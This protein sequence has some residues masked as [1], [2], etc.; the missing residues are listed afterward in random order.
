TAPA[1]PGGATA[2]A[3]PGGP[4][5]SPRP[6]RLQVRSSDLAGLDRV[7]S[8]GELA[9][10]GIP[11]VETD[12]GPAVVGGV[13]ERLDS[14][15]LP[16]PLPLTLP[17]DVAER[18][19]FKGRTGETLVVVPAEGPAVVFLGTGRPDALAIDV[20][21][22]AAAS[23][24]RSAGRRGQA[25]FVLPAALV[26]RLPAATGNPTPLPPAPRRAAQAVTGGAVLAAYRFTSHKSGDEAHH[27]DG[28]VVAGVDIEPEVLAE[29]VRRGT[30][31][32]RAVCFARDLV[33]EPPSTMTP[34]R[35]A[36]AAEEYLG[37]LPALSLEVWDEGRIEA[38]RLGGLLAV[39]RGSAEPP[40]LI[41]AAFE[42]ADPVEVEGRVPHV[43]LVGKGITFD[44]GGLSLKTAEGMTTMKTDMSGAAAVL[45]VVGACAELA[46]RVRVTAIAPMTENMPGGRAQKP[47]D[48]LVARNGRTIEVLNTDAEGRL[49]LADG[50]S[51]ASELEPDVIIDL[52]T[53]TGAAVVALGRT[54]AGLFANDDVLLERLGD[55]AVGAGERTWPL[56]LAD[57][58]R[59]DIDSEVADMKNIGKGGQ[60][61][62]IVAALLLERFVDDTAWA[63]LDIAG[64]ARSEEDS[65]VLTKGGT[66]FGVA[67]LLEFLERFGADPGPLRPAAP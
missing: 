64:P 58:Y 42:P 24:V 22:R 59:S 48:V 8:A 61:G 3:P 11:A 37:G 52:A 62:A 43:V 27:L 23:L 38:E 26:G 36:A 2:P 10:V 9:A 47:G 14:A 41:R 46:V 29:G 1:P 49:I 16:G 33:N 32:A 55:A 13:P 56:P 19:G 12:D 20:L 30:A 60:A 35:M 17:G 21:Q 4:T 6:S 28:M 7:L 53:L 57:E 67:T 25:V 63:H 15:L 66:G 39:A 65:G 45:A 44:S 31:V 40:R 51:L 5:S 34:A 18:R 54:I 50:L